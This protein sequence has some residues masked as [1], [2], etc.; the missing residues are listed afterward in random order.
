MRVHIAFAAKVNCRPLVEGRQLFS[1]SLE[2]DTGRELRRPAVV[3]RVRSD[4]AEVGCSPGEAGYAEE[5]VVGEVV[6]LG[7]K[8]QPGRLAEVQREAAVQANVPLIVARSVDV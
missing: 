1:D 5:S 4:L 7:P 3:I 2:L 6:H 8:V